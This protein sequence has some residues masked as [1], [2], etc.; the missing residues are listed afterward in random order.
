M[1][2]DAIEVFAD[3]ATDGQ[4][5]EM[6]DEHGPAMRLALARMDLDR[7]ERVIDLG[8]GNGWATRLIAGITGAATLG[9]DGGTEMVARA[10]RLSAGIADVAIAQAP[11]E[12]LP[13]ADGAVDRV[14]SMESL[15]Y[16]P[17]LAAAIAEIHRVLRPGGRAEVMVDCFAE[18]AVS[19]RWPALLDVVMHRLGAPEWEAAFGTGGFDPVT[20]ERL[21]PAPG[22][23]S[24]FESSEWILTIEEWR[25]VR[26]AGTLWVRG[27]KPAA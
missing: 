12:N 26:A 22:P 21:R 25:D 18:N 16:A 13:V 5:E 24:D 19:E 23:E 10:R 1:S 17:D 11:F 27:L 14:I 4:A 20:T 7:G 8:C 15:Y 2:K 9:F 3:W 6:A